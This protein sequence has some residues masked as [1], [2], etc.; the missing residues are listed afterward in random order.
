MQYIMCI[1]SYV[2]VHDLSPWFMMYLTICSRFSMISYTCVEIPDNFPYNIS[3]MFPWHNITIE[4]VLRAVTVKKW[5]SL[6]F[7]RTLFWVFSFVHKIVLFCAF[8][9]AKNCALDRARCISLLQ[10]LGLCQHNHIISGWWLQTFFMFHN[11]W[12][13]ILPIDFRIFQDG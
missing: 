1:Q 5:I 4:S 11:L 13:V 12:D 10:L 9:R 3:H 8:P 7:G 6:H 2:P